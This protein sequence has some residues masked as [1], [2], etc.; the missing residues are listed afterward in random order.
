M[1]FFEVVH[2]IYFISVI[3]R[4]KYSKLNFAFNQKIKFIAT[5]ATLRFQN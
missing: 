4:S 1:V 5:K 3:V 2:K